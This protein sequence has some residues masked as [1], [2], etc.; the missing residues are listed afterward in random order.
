MSAPGNR[1]ARSSEPT[2]VLEVTSAP[3][4]VAGQPVAVTVGVTSR[5][6]APRILAVQVVGLDPAWVPAPV[7]EIAVGPGER[8][9]ASFVV[10]VPAG[11][12]SGAFAFVVAAQALQPAT[13]VATGP[14]ATQDAVLQVGDDQHLTVRVE[15]RELRS[16]RTKRFRVLIS[17]PGDHDV[18]VDLEPVAPPQLT[19]QLRKTA[20]RVPARGEAK[21][22]GSMWLAR[23]RYL[24][25]VRRVPFAVNVVGGAVPVRHDGALVTRPALG[26]ALLKPTAFLLVIAL[27]LGAV[28]VGLQTVS[29]KLAKQTTL[30]AQ[31]GKNG[32][33]GGG[34]GGSGS[35]GAGGSG[36]TGKGGGGKGG[37]SVTTTKPVG[38]LNGT[39]TG[40]A[41]NGVTVSLQPTSLV[42]EKAEAAT[43][44]GFVRPVAYTEPGKVRPE[45]SAYSAATVSPKRSTTTAKDGAWAFAKVT[46]PGYYL[47]TFAKPGYQTRRYV[48]D[49]SVAAAPDAKPLSV[50]LSA[51]AGS[52][53]GKVTAAGGAAL[54]GATVTITDGDVT[55]STSSATKGA[56]GSW[57]V[58]GISTPGTY[59]VSVSRDGYGLQSRLVTLDA[60]RSGNVDFTLQTGQAA[61][62][63]TV[64][65]PDGLPLGG[66][67][68]TAT[69]GTVTRTATTLTNGAVGAFTLPAL[70]SPG[71]YTV[72]FSGRGFQPQTK[73]VVL[74]SGQSSANVTASL[75]S[76]TSI[77]LGTVV[78]EN[79]K[80]LVGAGL[81]LAGQDQT[82]K[83]MSGSDPVA[84]DGAFLFDGVAAG[85]YV[86]SAEMFGRQSDLAAV[87]V[88]GAVE[89][90]T[91]T[92]PALPSGGLL[93]TAHIQG[94][95]VD[96]RNGGKLTCV[97]G[98]KTCSL[99]I[100]AA[101]TD[102]R[103]DGTK[104]FTTTVGADQP[105]VLPD[106]ASKEG[107]LPGAHLV[108]ISVPGY[109][110]DQVV[111][112]VGQGQTVDAPTIALYPVGSITG[113]ITAA[114]G[115]VPAGTCV[116]AVAL[117]AGASPPTC[118]AA[119]T[120][121]EASRNTDVATA[122]KDATKLCASV[123]ADGSYAIKGLSRGTYLVG[124]FTPADSAYPSIAP[125]QVTL[126]PGGDQR[127]DAVLHRFG[128]LSVLVT[129]P[130]DSGTVAP[131]DKAQI[132][133][134]STALSQPATGTTGT[135]GTFAFTASQLGTA[136][137]VVTVTDPT[138]TSK[139][140]SATVTISPDQDVSVQVILIPDAGKYF[141][142][143]VS[144]VDG[145]N[146]PLDSSAGQRLEVTVTGVVGYVGN[147]PVTQTAVGYASANGCF[148]L[149]PPNQTLLASDYPSSCGI[150]DASAARI[151]IGLIVPLADVKVRVVDANNATVDTYVPT[152][153]SSVDVTGNPFTVVMSAQPRVVAVTA[154]AVEGKTCSSLTNADLSKLTVRVLS[155]PA[156]SGSVTVT[157]D[158]VSNLLVWRDTAVGTRDNYAVPGDYVLSVNVPN[159]DEARADISVP[160]AP[161]PTDAFPI[162][163]QL[164]PLTGFTVSAVT[165]GSGKT[166]TPVNGALFIIS[167]GNT[168]QSLTALPGTN[169]VTFQG[170]S[171][172]VAYSVEVRAAGY[173][174]ATSAGLKPSAGSASVT[175]TAL[176]AISGAVTSKT[177]G[178][179]IPSTTL[180]ACYLGAADT[181]ATTCAADATTFTAL[182]A[183]NGT[184]TITGDT[185]TEGLVDGAWLLSVKA[186]NGYSA[187]LD[188]A[189]VVTVGATSKQNVQLEPVSVS[190]SVSLIDDANSASPTAVTGAIVTA[191]GGDGVS[192][193]PTTVA[194]GV[195][196]FGNLAPDT[197]S[198]RVTASGYSP[199]QVIVTLRA[200]GGDQAITLALA[201][202]HNG[203]D[204]TVTGFTSTGA[205]PLPGA[206]VTVTLPDGTTQLTPAVDSSGNFATDI[207]L[208]DGTY[209]I[210]VAA[211][212][213]QT[214]STQLQ[215]LGGTV[216][217]IDV[218]LAR[219]SAQLTLSLTSPT[220]LS[221]GTTALF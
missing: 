51:G 173:S 187:P 138:D 207:N 53:T 125:A 30:S 74:A 190:L 217:H 203:I 80:G 134:T 75:A 156:G 66:I 71:T 101:T 144:G 118:A 189:V 119:S 62:T 58:D 89:P 178:E 116:S 13:R 165:A 211:S 45:L 68:V 170:L 105:Y 99:S 221:N 7:S 25:Q 174:F 193:A 57:H 128:K 132:T 216:A 79:G 141:G 186:P 67:T 168:T 115:S 169:S 14:A 85:D 27:W 24:G 183:G 160:V 104:T 96:A 162:A 114:V 191:T 130:N 194:G 69:N 5:S 43:F 109:E 212:N 117:A 41:A 36:G 70:P 49:S 146:I 59:L 9:E 11:V 135:D 143:V 12:P 209:T 150:T 87:H 167:G 94:R 121:P 16:S 48:I 91:L 95:V 213:Y 195:Y 18:A 198:V 202:N 129:K 23:R 157:Y 8:A 140:K 192:H 136:T 220:D 2:P 77:V 158:S 152:T 147:Q 145:G 37:S 142:R 72:S 55:V 56:V 50:E 210:S 171:S 3:V 34:D 107:L 46:A 200:G 97:D 111:V 208:G 73:Q 40:P 22:R 93:A 28:V 102:E 63:G 90:V 177:T 81:K 151:N 153:K 139:S 199:L 60:G 64:S 98:S 78:D 205:A 88:G 175:L 33:A 19:M 181:T 44:V 124:V 219:Q 100:T 123:N 148:A 103:P 131:V 185:S 149:A 84:G 92:L 6:D 133:I 39:V 10:N 164:K 20:V 86:L 166:T 159:Y 110:S 154:C 52:L 65:G 214:Y 61:L 182:S 120:T 76:L 204:G 113:L 172:D 155:Q 127:Y 32:E 15:P 54:G 38:R 108:T 126:P 179:A 122:C 47:L 83:T 176:G 82:Y 35:G 42:D 206:T 201:G 137:Y 1:G 26:P 21:V 4:V 163:L 180:S 215:L 197:Y 31:A 218:T 161:N 184:F 188:R 106:T 29:S 112:R 17:N 196:T